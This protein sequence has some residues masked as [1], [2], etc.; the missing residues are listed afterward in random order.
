MNDLNRTNIIVEQSLS[1]IGRGE[2][3]DYLAHAYCHEGSCTFTFNHKEFTMKTG[4]CMIVR[5][6]NLV[7]N[8]RPGETFRV[9]VIYVTPEFIQ[10]SAPQSNYGTKGGIMLFEN[11]IMHLTPEQQ[12]RCVLDFESI[13]R[14][15][16]LTEHRF[17]RDA[18]INAVQCMII[19][20][21]DFHAQ[22]F[23]E[24]NITSKYALIM[25]GFIALLE[26]G[27]YRHNRE[28]GYYADK[29]CIT[30]KYLS[31]VSKKISGF[32]ANYWIVRYT[33]L[34]I[35]NQLRDKR[36]TLKELSEYYNFPSTSYFN[37]YVQ[38]YLHVAPGDLRK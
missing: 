22:L 37:R 31:E 6:S 12:S 14:R 3:A 21:Y 33:T 2:L 28:I 25:N 24:G 27:D 26:Q 5:R 23:A 38:K 16:A 36:K 8:I 18:M 1:S 11:P 13:K 29:L 7:N 35:L 15:L 34:D 19:D 30:T 10:L 32:P 4:D 9:E 20:F 17:H